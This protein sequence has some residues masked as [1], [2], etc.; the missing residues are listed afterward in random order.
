MRK[1][2]SLRLPTEQHGAYGTRQEP[3]DDIF[4]TPNSPHSN[5]ELRCIHR[6]GKAER[7]VSMSKQSFKNVLNFHTFPGKLGTGKLE[8]NLGKCLRGM[9]YPYPHMRIAVAVVLLLLDTSALADHA[10]DSVTQAVTCSALCDGS[11]RSAVRY[12][13]PG[14]S[15]TAAVVGNFTFPGGLDIVLPELQFGINLK[16]SSHRD[17]SSIADVR[18]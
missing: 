5:L 1:T 16:Y 12:G 10:R 15:C 18:V 9:V 17:N 7:V 4:L 11:A 8:R 3:T 14:T 13:H 2:C 6:D